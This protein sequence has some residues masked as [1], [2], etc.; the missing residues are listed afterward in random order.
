MH[1]IDFLHMNNVN[2]YDLSYILSYK[3]KR[4]FD[5]Y[6]YVY[7][8]ELLLLLLI[9]ILDLIRFLLVFLNKWKGDRV[10]QRKEA[11][12]ACFLTQT[13]LS[14]GNKAGA[15]GPVCS[16]GAV[17]EE[18]DQALFSFPG[19]L[20]QKVLTNEQHLNPPLTPLPQ[21]SAQRT[22]PPSSNTCSRLTCAS[23]VVLKSL[24]HT[25]LYTVHIHTV[26]STHTHKTLL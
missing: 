26:Y 14:Q 13:S 1:F 3:K 17:C 24:T 5:Y 25:A 23:V 8:G 7:Y 2:L 4:M 22:P 21:V 15:H 18:M 6:C 20:P 9:H 10:N 16:Q 19:N 11:E 12:G